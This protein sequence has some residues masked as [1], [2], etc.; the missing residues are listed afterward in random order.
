MLSVYKHEETFLLFCFRL[1]SL[2]C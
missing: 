1:A 2:K